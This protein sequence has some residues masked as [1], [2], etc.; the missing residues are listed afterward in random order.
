MAGGSHDVPLTSPSACPEAS[1]ASNDS[2]FQRFNDLTSCGLAPL[3]NDEWS[4]LLHQ[5]IQFAEYQISRLHWRGDYG[6]VLPEGFD[7]KSLAAQAVANFLANR[8]SPLPLSA[9]LWQLKGHVLR[10]VS[11]LHHLKENWLV[12]SEADLAPVRDMDGEPVSP[13]EL[14]PAPDVRPDKALLHQESVSQFHQ[15]KSRFEAFL[16]KDRALINLLELGCD[17][18]SKPQAVAAHLKIGIRTIRNQRKRLLRQWRAFLRR[19]STREG[20][21]KSQNLPNILR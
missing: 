11:R 6:G 15:L 16:A 3:T 1:P 12:S 20:T 21:A 7:A 2:T 14:I 8:T 18:I 9:I 19:L 5:T 17:G 10:H 4:F 13:I